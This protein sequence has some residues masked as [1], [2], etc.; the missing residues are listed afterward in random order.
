MYTRSADIELI[1]Q[2]LAQWFPSMIDRIV[3][4]DSVEGRTISALRIHAGAATNRRGVLFVGGTHARE[5]LNPDALVDLTIGLLSH[6]FNGTD[7]VIGGRTWDAGILRSAMNILD[8]VILPNANPDGREYVF[9]VERMWRKNRAPLTGTTCVGVDLNRNF[10]LLWGIET[11]AP[12]GSLTTSRSPCS[13][14]YFGPDAFSEPET[15]NV[16]ML[17]DNHQIDCMVDVHSFSE[18]VL[19]PWGHAPNQTTDPT[20]RFTLVDTSTWKELPRD[21]PDYKEYIPPAD[22]ER[23][24]KVGAAAAQAI[25]DVR[26]R[27][28]TVQSGIDLYATTGTQSDYAYARHVADPALRKVY[29]FTFETGPWTGDIEESFQPPF[30]EANRIME[31]AI[32]GLLS[33]LHSNVCAIDLI[34]GQLLG[35]DDGSLD[36]MRSVRDQQL[37]GTGEG[38]AWIAMLERHDAELV[39][40]A[41][42]DD[43]FK[44]VVGEL[45]MLAGGIL[46]AGQFD[47]DYAREVRSVLD[48][49]ERAELSAEL[50][51][52]LRRL[53]LLTRQ[54]EGRPTN[55]A[56]DHLRRVPP[57]SPK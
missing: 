1:N 27:T 46:R 12:D 22:L 20:Q 16:K 39:Q 42:R 45:I 37:A 4:A 35:T 57:T 53:H 13:F 7:W 23:F 51:A 44:H 36:A 11:R 54:L 24:K 18:L 21:A 6:Y 3:L 29:G 43:A 31:E 48:Q 56:I 33:V 52:D 40:I 15:R 55:E 8:I 25:K 14:V 5:L 19:Y 32:S 30:P 49:L 41:S 34:G 9:D 10:D 2:T 50:R 26:G 47:S 38:Q 17:L 28:Y